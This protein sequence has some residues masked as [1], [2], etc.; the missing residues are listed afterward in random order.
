MSVLFDEN[1]HIQWL[2][3]AVKIDVGLVESHHRGVFGS[4]I[5]LEK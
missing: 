3:A 2:N 4:A 1:R 5:T